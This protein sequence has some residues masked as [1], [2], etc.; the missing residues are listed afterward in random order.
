VSLPRSRPL[1]RRSSLSLTLPDLRLAAVLVAALAAGCRRDPDALT[2]RAPQNAPTPPALEFVLLWDVPAP[3]CPREIDPAMTGQA[4]LRDASTGTSIRL[5]DGLEVPAAAEPPPDPPPPA[6]AAEVL[7]R[8]PEFAGHTSLTPWGGWALFALPAQRT[9]VA[10]DVEKERVAWQFRA[11][12]ATV[13]A[14]Q[15]VRGRVVLVSLDN[16]LYCLRA[17]NGHEIWRA[18]TAARLDLATAFWRDR[19]IAAPEGSPELEAFHLRDGSRAGKFPLG[20]PAARVI[21]APAVIE[22]VL[23]VAYARYGSPAC[24]LRAA[25]LREG[26]SG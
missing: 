10:F 20:D 22:D 2:W 11:A 5:E 15:V 7:D 21:A 18:R 19:V 12:A 23:V 1:A 8:H 16:H 24:R 4:G 25:R 26:G 3:F 9:L 6:A 14:P 17:K 13:V